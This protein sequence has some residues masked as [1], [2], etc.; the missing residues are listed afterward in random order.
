MFRW[1]G[2]GRHQINVGLPQ[3]IEIDRKPENGCEIQNVADG[4][5]G[6]MIQLKFVKTSSEEDLHST[7]KHDGFLHGTKAI[8]NILQPWLNTQRR[9]VIA[10][11]YFVLVQS[12]GDLNKL[13]LRFIG[14]VKTAI[15]GF[16][17]EKL[18][19]I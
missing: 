7:E 6:I 14:L 13:G 18:L 11:S 2:I 3:Y 8:F 19:D 12:C 16:C 17:M 9:V 1:Y 10:D 4:V 5:Y 15:R